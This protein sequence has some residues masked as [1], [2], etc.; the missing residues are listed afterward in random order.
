MKL[1]RGEPGEPLEGSSPTFEEGG[2][3]GEKQAS[4]L[5]RFPQGSTGSGAEQRCGSPDEARGGSGPVACE[6]RH[7]ELNDDLWLMI[8][9]TLNIRDRVMLEGGVWEEKGKGEES[10]RVCVRTG[11][12]LMLV[13]VLVQEIFSELSLLCSSV[14]EVAEIGNLVLEELEETQL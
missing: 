9:S 2:L 7:P 14:P 6:G 13:N 11:S 5:L 3:D 10:G 12:V 4:E 8:F 1:A